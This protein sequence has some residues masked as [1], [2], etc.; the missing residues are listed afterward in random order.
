MNYLEK[1]FKNGCNMGMRD[2]PDMYAQSP[3]AACPRDEGIHIRQI[4]NAH[5]TSV[6]Q[7]FHCHSNNTSTL[8]V[9]IT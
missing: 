5:A 8:N 6:M 4:P 7:H 3:G 9:T 2:L 1:I